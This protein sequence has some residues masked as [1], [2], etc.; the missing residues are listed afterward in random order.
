MLTY[1]YQYGNSPRTVLK[2]S[3]DKKEEKVRTLESNNTHVNTVPYSTLE[4]VIPS[5]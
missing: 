5:P 1:G 2:P 3:T 4:R